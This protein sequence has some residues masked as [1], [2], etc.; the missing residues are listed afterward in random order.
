MSLPRECRCCRQVKQIKGRELCRPCYKR[1]ARHGTLDSL[2][3]LPPKVVKQAKPKRVPKPKPEPKDRRSW[4]LVDDYL[5]LRSQGETFEAA[6]QR[7]G[8]TPGALKIAL[9]RRKKWGQL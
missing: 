9:I 4:D 7:L 2:Y 8:K 5:F 6:A 3:P 1:A